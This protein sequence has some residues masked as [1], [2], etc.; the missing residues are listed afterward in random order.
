MP[1][2]MDASPDGDGERQGEVPLIGFYQ[3]TNLSGSINTAS[4][5]K[6]SEASFSILPILL[7]DA[8]LHCPFV[9]IFYYIHHTEKFIKLQL[10]CK[11]TWNFL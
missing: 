6:S 10:H 1:A 8:R 11:D 7:L 3:A 2:T 4:T 5:I 9:P